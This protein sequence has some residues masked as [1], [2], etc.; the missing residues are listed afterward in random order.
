MGRR[1][2][3]VA[4]VSP[5]CDY[6]RGHGSRELLAEVSGGRAP[7]WGSRVR[8]WHCQPS[9]STDAIAL[10]ESRGW[11]VDI[12]DEAHLLRLAGIEVDAVRAAHAE[13]RGALW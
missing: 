2:L 9:T 6:W 8:A 4:H 13:S 7:L 10:A 3:E 11:H 12:I 1:V 5:S